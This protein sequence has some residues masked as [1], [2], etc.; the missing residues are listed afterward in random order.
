MPEPSLF[1]DLPEPPATPEASGDTA[2]AGAPDLFSAPSASATA[3]P[4]P[5]APSSDDTPPWDEPDADAPDDAPEASGEDDEEGEERETLFLADAM[6]LAYRAFFSM[7]NA[8]MNAPDGTD[9]RTLYGFATALLKLLEDHQPEHIAVVFDPLT[10]GPNFRDELYEDYK[11]H[12]PPMPSEIKSCIPL[13]KDLCRGFDI[14]VLEVDGMEADDVIGTL[15][16][17]A[18]GEGVDVVIF[19]AD[20]DFRQLLSDEASG[21]GPGCVHMLRPPYM[22]EVFNRETAE[23]F[24]EKYDGLEPVQFIELLAL[25]GDS[26][27]NVPGVPG[28]GEKTAI[29][30][31]KQYKTVENLIEHRDEVKGKRANDGLTNHAE[32]A[33]LSKKLV[34]IATDLDVTDDFGDP[35]DWHSLRRTD[36]DI[37]ALNNLF[38]HVGFGTRLRNRVKDYAEGRERTRAS[39][40]Y[41]KRQ[42]TH[43]PESDPSLDFDFGPYEPVTAMDSDAVSYA[44]VYEKA[45]LGTAAEEAAGEPLAFDTETTSVDA[46]EA[47]LVGVSLSSKEKR[48]VYVPT[49]LP[50]GTQTQ[51]ALDA[52]R[53]RLEDPGVEKV[54]HNVKYDLLVLG[55]H[56]VEVAGPFFDTMVAHYLI[57]PEASHKLDD[58]SSFYLNYRP[59]PIT[60]LI[61]TGKNALN[62]RD[63]PVEDVGPYACEDADI[64]L[65]LVPLL[66]QK[67]IDDKLLAIAEEIEFPL[68]PVL[69]DIERRGVKV[70]VKVLDKISVQLEA[71]MERIEKEVG[72]LAG[73]V[74]NI[75]SPKQIGEI[76]FNDPPTD[77]ERAAAAQWEQDVRDNESGKVEGDPDAKPKTKKQLAEEAPTWGLGLQPLAKTKSGAPSTAENVLSE[78]AQEHTLPALILDWRKV[79]KLKSTYADRLPELIH[80]ETG[81]IHTDFNQT[82]TATG[83]LSSSNPNLQ[84][85]PIRT[86][87]GREIRRAFVAAD[88]CK[89]LAADYAQIEL[90]IIAHMSQDA[91]LVEAFSEGRDIHTAT[92][93]RVFDVD[94][95]D[96]TRP[97]RDRVKQVNYGIPY[98]ISAFGLANRMR[99]SNSE[100]QELID[101]YRASYPTVIRF[102]DGLVDDAR[103]RG[104]AETL[105]GRRR[106]LPQL[107]SRNPNDR[108]YSERIALNMPIQGTQADMIKRAMVSLHN[109]LPLAGLET[110]M[111]LQV[112]DELV[113]EV[114][115]A[116]VDAA[117][118]LIRREMTAAFPLD[119]PVVVD[120]GVADNWLDAH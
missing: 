48:A 103:A 15:C 61:G 89:L 52:I 97:Q 70:D 20:K 77:E 51:E 43:L 72:E 29:K 66:R 11:A 55:N 88:G 100:A 35:L 46:M 2:P 23:T 114:P 113:F 76:L 56:G 39:G 68:V 47:S 28:I 34:T 60:D 19:S 59:Q 9:T 14:P 27:D 80:P 3:E 10:G 50:D 84:N 33:L 18:E 119:V 45:D 120:V 1:D 65:R 13:I 57:E 87:M 26:A 58:V 82:V 36:P 86:E 24:R 109:A 79:S 106:Y 7:K 8:S 17:R 93:A 117:T 74:F 62:M 22:G 85:I 31:I 99:I 12:R 110:R 78:L 108:A 6:A 63:V 49:P 112:H 53:Q 67:L 5:E 115:L 38:D 21:A 107:N 25:M 101:Q 81:R 91:G 96:V 41:R 111:I 37:G 73:R 30:L 4:A 118:E 90:R 54:G 16:R 69:A 42:S 95:E 40:G 44:T 105:L 102:L 64:T 71:E 104:Y 92:A 83:R 98:G 75:G 116:E 94:Y 32:D